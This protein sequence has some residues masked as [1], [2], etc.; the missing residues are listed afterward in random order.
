MRL[1]GV[2][3]VTIVIVSLFM[4]SCDSPSKRLNR[5]RRAQTAREAKALTQPD[6]VWTFIPLSNAIGRDVGGSRLLFKHAGEM[7][8]ADLTACFIVENVQDTVMIGWNI[9]LPR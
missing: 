9:Y 6:S 8:V 1:L 7:H 5:E 4:F 3:L 2:Y